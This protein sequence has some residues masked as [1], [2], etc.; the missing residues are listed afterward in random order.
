[1][2]PPRGWPP[3]RRGHRRPPASGTGSRRGFGKSWWGAAWVDA[4]TGRASLDPNRLP[5]GRSYARSGAVGELQVAPG[6]VRAAVQGT[7]ARPYDVRVRVRQFDDP[8]WTRLLDVVAARVGHAAALLD[9]ELPPEF[10]DDVTAAGLELLPGPG[11]LQPRC[12]CPDWADPCKHAAAVCF[13]VADV[14]DADPFALLLL[15][16]R[17]RDAVLAAL[18][19]RRG[20]ATTDPSPPREQDVGV[21]ARQ[22]FATPER[23]PLP[24]PPLPPN[25][26]G[27]PAA[28]AVDPPAQSGLDAHALSALAADAA[29][30]AHRLL[31]GAGDADL[32]LDRDA[33]LARRAAQALGTPEFD[34]LARRA[35]VPGPELLRRSLAWRYGGAGGLA[36][37]GEP[38]QPDVDDLDEGR[39][40]LGSGVHVRQNR[41]TLGE[42]QLR[43][44]ADGR[45][46]PFQRRRRDWDP[47]GAAAADPAD[48]LACFGG[49]G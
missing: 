7:R 26:P 42:R 44:G 9:G 24:L 11:D 27:R 33:D 18:R 2:N 45:W 4:L 10:L 36:V 30:R 14:L 37:L 31:H 47:A 29:Q 6:E 32:T 22:A 23:A 13:L 48:A 41:L 43:L 12:T 49:R 28:L 20:G 8:D 16:G 3:E 5:R 39:H 17:G 35:G 1:M 40:A 19:A 38:W 46:Y 15:R 21:P 34:R 25:R